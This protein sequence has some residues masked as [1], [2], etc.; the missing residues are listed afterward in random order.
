MKRVLFLTDLHSGHLFSLTPPDY[1]TPLVNN[2]KDDLLRRRN[3]CAL[4]QRQM[5]SWFSKEIKKNGPFDVL[6]VGGDCVDGPG[7][8]SGGTELIS[9]DLNVQA[10]IATEVIKF[11]NAKKIVM[12]YG[13]PYHVGDQS[14]S[15]DVEDIIAQK[16]GADKIGSH[17]WVDVDGVVFDIKH[18]AGRSSIPHGR[19]TLISKE[20]LWSELW[21]S[22]EMTPRADVILRGHVHYPVEVNDPGLG[23]RAITGPALQWSTKYGARIATGMVNV[24]FVVFDINKGSYTCKF[25]LAKLGSQKTQAL[26]L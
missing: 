22:A 13:T 12:V 25:V 11:V 2:P 19:G 8:K 17:E 20:W 21:A 1:W 5:W 24:G 10:E 6:L 26:R 7:Y 18:H 3:K 16:V 9:S 4:V 15:I 14:Q 23:Y